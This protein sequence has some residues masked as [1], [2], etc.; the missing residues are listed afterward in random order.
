MTRINR[1]KSRIVIAGLLAGV[2]LAILP[3]SAQT[4][5]PPSGADQGSGMMRPGMPNGNAMKPGMMMDQDM[6]QKMSHMMDNCNRMMESMT[7]K[8]DGTPTPSA[9]TNKG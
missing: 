8:R 5:A 1:T 3:A 6:Q 9:P 2:T 4:K 7:P